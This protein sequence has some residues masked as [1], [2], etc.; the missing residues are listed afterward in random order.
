[1]VEGT[2]GLI[3]VGGIKLG[4]GNA[5]SLGLSKAEFSVFRCAECGTLGLFAYEPGSRARTDDTTSAPVNWHSQYIC[6]FCYLASGIEK[7]L[8]ETEDELPKVYDLS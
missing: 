3:Q 8:D 5:E 7:I 1:M 2:T 4:S 6:G